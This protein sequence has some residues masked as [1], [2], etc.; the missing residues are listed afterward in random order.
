MCS[1][2]WSPLTPLDAHLTTLCCHSNVY[3]KYHQDTHRRRGGGG[4]EEGRKGGGG[5]IREEGEGEGRGDQDTVILTSDVNRNS[6]SEAAILQDLSATRHAI[7]VYLHRKLRSN[8][9]NRWAWLIRLVQLLAMP[10]KG[11]GKSPGPAGGKS[12]K[13]E[14]LPQV[15]LPDQV[16]K[17]R[18]MPQVLSNKRGRG[19][20]GCRSLPFRPPLGVKH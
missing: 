11:K 10:K 3:I 12:A 13:P 18:K 1:L 20:K 4:E 9:V 15:W 7:S 2:E 16:S 6:F 19:C 14:A 17:C 8:S 5:R